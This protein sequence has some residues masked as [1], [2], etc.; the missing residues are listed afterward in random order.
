MT[1]FVYMA[2][3]I[4]TD[5]DSSGFSEIKQHTEEKVGQCRRGLQN[6]ILKNKTIFSRK[7]CLNQFTINDFFFPHNKLTH[8]I[9]LS[10]TYF[11]LPV[12]MI[13][14]HNY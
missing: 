8:R 7:M 2:L 12:T 3:C 4:S 13:I 9:Q 1:S 10:I 6:T 5:M 11:D 14:L